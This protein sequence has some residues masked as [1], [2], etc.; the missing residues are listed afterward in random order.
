VETVDGTSQTIIIK[1]EGSQQSLLNNPSVSSN[2]AQNENSLI[3]LSEESEAQETLDA[4]LGDTNSNTVSSTSTSATDSS[5]AGEIL[6]QLTH[7]SSLDH[8][9]I[10]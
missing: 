7:Q 5:S 8:Q 1:I 2:T 10:S 3:A 4:F 9:V 6:Q